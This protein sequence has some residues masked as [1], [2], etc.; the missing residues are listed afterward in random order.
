MVVAVSR[1]GS[2]A[3]HSRRGSVASHS[4]VETPETVEVRI[5][6]PIGTKRSQ[7]RISLRDGDREAWRNEIETA[8]GEDLPAEHARL[9]VQPAFWPEPL[10]DGTLRGAVLLKECSFQMED[11]GVAGADGAPALRE[12]H[13]VVVL[14]KRSPAG[15]AEARDENGSHGTVWW[16][17]VLDAASPKQPLA[18]PPASRSSRCG[19]GGMGESA[20]AEAAVLVQRMAVRPG[21]VDTQRQCARGCASL[22]RREGG[23]AALVSAKAPRRACG[24]GGGRRVLG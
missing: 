8:G 1:R 2:V 3:S 12:T 24:E 5:K 6:L 17:G 18:A 9:T 14:R 15:H 10:L 4:W 11:D 19:S 13:L 20:S 21:D 16:G 23:A 22:A 7:L